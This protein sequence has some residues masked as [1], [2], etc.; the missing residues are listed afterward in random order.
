MRDAGAFTGG[1]G[2]YQSFVHVDT[3]GKNA[4]FGPLRHLVFS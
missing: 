3:R 4:N 1:I 2:V